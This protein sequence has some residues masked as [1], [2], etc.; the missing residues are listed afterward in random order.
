VT[1]QGSALRDRLGHYVDSRKAAVATR[2]VEILRETTPVDTGAARDAWEIRPGS[3]G[4]LIVG[5]DKEYVRYLNEGSSSQAPA[6][7]VEAAL[8]QAVA[9]VQSE[10]G[11]AGVRKR[12]VRIDFPGST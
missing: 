10:R 5:N 8:E 6:G 4:T 9:D 12:D 3:A 2:L 11:R 7:F 1:R